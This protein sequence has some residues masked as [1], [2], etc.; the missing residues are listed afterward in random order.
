[1]NYKLEKKFIMYYSKQCICVN[2]IVIYYD[3]TTL[4]MKI[5]STQQKKKHLI[6]SFYSNM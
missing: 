2:F 3:N 1:M 5:K 4:C 6:H